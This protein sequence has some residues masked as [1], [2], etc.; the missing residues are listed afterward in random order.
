MILKL[1]DMGNS[2]K[3]VVKNFGP[4]KSAE[5]DLKKT[6][7]IIGEQASGKSTIAKIIYFYKSL[8]DDLFSQVFS[9]STPESKD[10]DIKTA[11]VFEARDKFKEL[12]GSTSFSKDT[13]IVFYFQEKPIANYLRFFAKNSKRNLS[14]AQTYCLFVER[15]VS[16]IALRLSAKRDYLYSCRRFVAKIS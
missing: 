2:Q 9:K 3:I 5:I 16:S 7:V 1:D 13:E 4:I 14:R 10:Y 6:I 12:F 11:F 8:R 15:N